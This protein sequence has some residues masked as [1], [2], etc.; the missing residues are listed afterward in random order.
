VL[1]CNY[2]CS[3]ALGFCCILNRR[4]AQCAVLSGTVYECVSLMNFIEVFHIP[5]ERLFYISH[6]QQCLKIADYYCEYQIHRDDVIVLSCERKALC[7]I[8]YYV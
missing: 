8:F 3:V 1:A 5:Y 2:S 4:L 7:F 6:E